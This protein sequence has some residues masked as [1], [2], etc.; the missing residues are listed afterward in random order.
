MFCPV[1]VEDRGILHDADTPDD[2]KAL[3]DYHNSRL[4]RPEISLSVV[5]EKVFL[6]DRICMMLSLIEETGSVRAACQRMQI[7]YSTGW[8]ILRT[9]ETQLQTAIVSRTQGGSGGGRSSLT[10]DG[11]ALLQAFLAYEERMREEAALLF[12]DYF[13]DLFRS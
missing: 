13:A 4:I 1:P 8:N 3:L 9:M 10:G 12:T 2:Y 7:S 5:K 6:D 11:K